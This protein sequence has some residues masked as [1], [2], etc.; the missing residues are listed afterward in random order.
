MPQKK[1][2]CSANALRHKEK[3]HTEHARGRYTPKLRANQV[4]VGG[5]GARLPM[6]ATSRDSYSFQ[7]MDGGRH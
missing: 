4:D 3:M 2:G 1:K 7:F 5:V 6:G